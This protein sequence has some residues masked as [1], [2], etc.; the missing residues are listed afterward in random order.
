MIHRSIEIGEANTVVVRV[1]TDCTI[2]GYEGTRVLA[3]TESRWGGL[4]VRERDGVIEVGAG[5]ACT[6]KMPAQLALKI[7]CGKHATVTHVRGPVLI[8]AGGHAQVANVELLD[9]ANAGGDLDIDCERL[10]TTDTRMQAGKDIRI[11]VRDLTSAQVQVNDVGGY[12]EGQI[13]AGE[14]LLRLKCG[15]VATLITD[16]PVSGRVLGN[17]ERPAEGA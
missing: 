4:N 14:T 3:E 15:G 6:V 7:Y 5:G 16:Q 8:Q 12:W 13:G 1:G 10:T 2:E 9:P 11:R 17:I